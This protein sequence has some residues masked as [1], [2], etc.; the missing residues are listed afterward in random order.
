MGYQ[1]KDLRSIRAQHFLTQQDL[2]EK[3]KVSIPTICNA[4]GGGAVS[5]GTLR[6]LAAALDMKPEKLGEVKA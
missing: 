1:I 2:S 4:E 6:K 5:L 3:A